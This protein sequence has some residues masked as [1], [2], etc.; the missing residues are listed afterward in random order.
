MTRG[1]V[2]E[3][4]TTPTAG[5]AMIS[6]T[7]SSA[8]AGRGLEGD[9]YE[10]G[11]GFYSKHPITSGARELTLIDEAAVARVALE[12]GVPF[13]TA[14]SR[15]N[16]I[17]EGVDLDA[18]IGRAFTIGSVTCEGVRS[19]PPCVHLDELLGREVMPALVRTGGLRARIVQGGSIRV[20]DVVAVEGP[21][22]GAW[23]GNDG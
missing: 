10:Q 6:R 2:L 17:T 23:V 22:Q 14:D 9:R 7:E 15:R 19:C 20:G 16:L 8:I 3:I 12:T 21:A 4:F 11:I 13:S 5:A 18:L 1:T